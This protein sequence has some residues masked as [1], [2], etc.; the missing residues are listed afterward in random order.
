MDYDQFRHFADSWGLVYL[1][2]IFVIV[3]LFVFR[4]GSSRLYRDAASIPLDD[5]ADDR[6]APRQQA[7]NPTKRSQ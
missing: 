5:H 1:F 7:Q 2:S 3:L 4:P 6:P